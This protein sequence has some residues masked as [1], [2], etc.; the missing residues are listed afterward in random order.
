[1]DT[2]AESALTSFVSWLG[3]RRFWSGA[4]SST[5]GLKIPYSMKYFLFGTGNKIVSCSVSE[6]IGMLPLEEALCPFVSP[7]KMAANLLTTLRWEFFY[8]MCRNMQ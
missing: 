1:M 4:F 7:T 3:A 5:Y 6:S 2:V 8:S